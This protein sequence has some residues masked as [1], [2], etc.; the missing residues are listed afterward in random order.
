MKQASNRRQFLKGSFSALAGLITARAIRLFPEAQSIFAKSINT[1][2]V[3][4][5]I[6]QLTEGEELYEGFLLLPEGSPVPSFVQCAPAPILCHVH[7]SNNPALVG[8]TIGVNSIQELKEFL[9]F[10]IY[11]PTTLPLNMRFDTATVIRFAQSGLVFMATVNYNTSDLIQLP[12][13]VLAQPIF[14]RPYP[15]WPVRLPDTSEGDPVYAEK[16]SFL[17]SPGVMRLSVPG[18]VYQ[19]IQQDILYTLV[20]EHDPSREAAELIAKSLQQN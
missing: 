19:W 17:P 9:S 5:S 3:T 8:E 12:I 14:P 13:S 18:H 10:P 16:V 1:T 7:E 11:T 4:Q 20:I 6:E 2:P 15:I